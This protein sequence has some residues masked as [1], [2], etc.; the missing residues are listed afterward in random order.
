MV[1]LHF[2][3][4]EELKDLL[5]ITIGLKSLKRMNMTVSSTT[6]DGAKIGSLVILKVMST[7]AAMEAAPVEIGEIRHIPIV[8]GCC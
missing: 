5:H 7:C 3:L 4:K 1:A 8:W 6:T 2:V